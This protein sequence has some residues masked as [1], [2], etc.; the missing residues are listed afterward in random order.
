MCEFISALQLQLSIL[1]VLCSYVHEIS[2]L[3]FQKDSLNSNLRFPGLMMLILIKKTHFNNRVIS[4]VILIIC[5]FFLKIGLQCFLL[6]LSIRLSVR[7]S[8]RLFIRL[9]VR[10]SKRLSLPIRWPNCIL[11]NLETN[12]C[13][14]SSLKLILLKY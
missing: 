4:I 5:Y 8:V 6:R 13:C 12:E 3:L 2:W 14:H 9:T 1:Y 11:I 7:P 10:L